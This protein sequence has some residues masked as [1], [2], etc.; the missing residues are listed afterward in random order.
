MADRGRG[1]TRTLWPKRGLKEEILVVNMAS[2]AEKEETGRTKTKLINSH[3][4]DA[5][6]LN[7]FKNATRGRGQWQH[8]VAV[9]ATAAA[10]AA[11]RLNQVN[12]SQMGF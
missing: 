12:G 10:A 2:L 1:P 7:A 4:G 9:A 3:F 6:N 5:Y 11:A 8:L